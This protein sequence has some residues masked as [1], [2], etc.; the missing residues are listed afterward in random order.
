MGII[1]FQKDS[2]S[3]FL[4]FVAET[5]RSQIQKNCAT[6]CFSKAYLYDALPWNQVSYIKP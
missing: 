6:L 1:F 5:T 2:Y 4:L 3:F